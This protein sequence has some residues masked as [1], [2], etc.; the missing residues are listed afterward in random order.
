M[1]LSS[2][3]LR[4]TSRSFEQA[5]IRRDLKLPYQRTQNL[6]AQ[7]VVGK[8]YSAACAQADATGFVLARQ[9]TVQSIGEVL[10]AANRS[11]DDSSALA[12][13]GE[14]I[15]DQ[16]AEVSYSLSILRGLLDDDP[17]CCIIPVLPNSLG[18]MDVTRPGYIPLNS[19]NVGSQQD[20]DWAWITNNSTFVIH[21]L[22]QAA[23]R[24]QKQ[25]AEIYFASHR[26]ANVRED[27]TFRSFLTSFAEELSQ[28]ASSSIMARIDLD[29]FSLAICL[30]FDD[31]QDILFDVFEEKTR[32]MSTAWLKVDCSLAEAVID[33]MAGRILHLFKLVDDGTMSEEDLLD[34]AIENTALYAIRR[35]IDIKSN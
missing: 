34:S 2:T 3:V 31:L 35:F 28:A 10:S 20:D 5:L 22:N 16:I 30:D 4:S 8:P 18:L 19:F 25:C 13:F 6:W 32:K 27:D 24:S 17:S 26:L 33:H 1:K 7:I 12:I 11:V 14:S 21:L 23:G 9:I 29:S 15:S